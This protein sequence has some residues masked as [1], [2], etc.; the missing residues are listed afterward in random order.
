M[1]KKSRLIHESRMKLQSKTRYGESKDELK[2]QEAERARKAGETPR[3]IEGIF[4]TATYNSYAKNAKY[5]IEWAIQNHPEVKTLK[6]CKPYVKDFLEEKEYEGKSPWTLGLYGSTCGNLFDCSKN[7]FGYDYPKRARSQITRTRDENSSDKH[8][9]KYADVIRF[10]R[11]TGCRR[12]GLLRLRPTDF[13]TNE[14]GELEVFKREKGG[15]KRWTLVVPSEAD[16]VKEFVRNCQTRAVHGEERILARTQLPEGSI[17]DCRADYT[18][19][20]YEYFKGRGDVESGEMYCCRGDM[21]GRHY[22]K[23]ILA[24]CSYNLC[25]SRN[26]VVV[27]HYMYKMK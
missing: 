4:S 14:R 11:A 10:A 3:P 13:R 6:D 26:S 23:G 17:H 18:A 27:S 15:I 7:D 25:H 21:I 20:L 9:E 22:D 19:A 1:S 12:A 2:K 16:F 5:F 8:P 24:E